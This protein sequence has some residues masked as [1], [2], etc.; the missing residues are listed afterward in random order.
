MQ[1]YL[2][3]HAA[4]HITVA[5]IGNGNFNRFGNRTPKR[6]GGAGE[7]FQ[8]LPPDICGFGRR[9][10]HRGTVGPHHFTAEGFLLIGHLHHEDLAV[11][12]E[13]GAG[14]GKRRTPLAGTGFRRN[15]FE[16]LLFG[17]VGLGNR[18]IQ[19]V[20]SGSIVAFKLVV[21]FGRCLQLFLKAV[22]PDKRRGPIHFVKVQDLRRNRVF[23]GLII[24]F[25]P[26]Q[27]IAEDHAEFFGCHRLMRGRIQQ[28]S[29]LVLHVG[30]DIVPILRHFLFFEIDLVG[31]CLFVCHGSFS[32]QFL[33]GLRVSEQ[34]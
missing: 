11:Q 21:D 14:H 7:L 23:T 12:P 22:C 3:Q 31:D 18:G 16:A 20:A 24:Q 27:L 28:G 29:R 33:F 34:I 19:L 9:R 4:E 5:G 8:N 1:K 10:N 26:D 2:V 13:I 32:F 30:A 6:A 15:A 25:L 17:V